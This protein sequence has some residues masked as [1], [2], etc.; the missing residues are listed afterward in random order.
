M[1]LKQILAQTESLTFCGCQS[2][3]LLTHKYNKLSLSLF[4]IS[5]NSHSLWSGGI[6]S[7]GIL[8]T[9]CKW[10]GKKFRNG[11]MLAYCDIV[12]VS[13]ALAPL[14]LIKHKVKEK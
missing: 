9:R 8:N 2:H 5:V 6:V 11:N 4:S 14:S 10:G 7:W 1:Y 13:S 3:C 12:H